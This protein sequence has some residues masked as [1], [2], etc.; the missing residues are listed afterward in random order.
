MKKLK[1]CLQ[2]RFLFFKKIAYIP[3]LPKTLKFLAV[4]FSTSKIQAL[5]KLAEKSKK[6]SFRKAYF[7][8][9]LVWISLQ[10]SI[11]FAVLKPNDI[12]TKIKFFFCGRIKDLMPNL[13][14]CFLQGVNNENLNRDYKQKKF[15]LKMRKNCCFFFKRCLSQLQP[16]LSTKKM[17]R[18]Q[19]ASRPQ[20]IFKTSKTPLQ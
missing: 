15:L 12:G 2:S 7:L 20:K 8:P 9:S 5:T 13:Y 11:I 14:R 19:R 4:H 18:F 3:Y 16:R 6:Q 10:H 1:N 17:Y